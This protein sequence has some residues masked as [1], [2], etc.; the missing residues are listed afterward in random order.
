MKQGREEDLKTG[1]GD[2]QGE[3]PMVA[4]SLA[5]QIAPRPVWLEGGARQAAGDEDRQA[6]SI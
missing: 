6:G 3:G 5:C 4:V 2:S 1:Q